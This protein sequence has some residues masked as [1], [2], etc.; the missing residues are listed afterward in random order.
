MEDLLTVDQVAKLVKM[1]RATIFRRMKEGSFP[2]PLRLSP[3][4]MFWTAGVIDDYLT[5]LRKQAFKE[6]QSIRKR[7]SK[8]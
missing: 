4:K 6:T 2:Q 3:K 7:L 1:S 8:K 5:D